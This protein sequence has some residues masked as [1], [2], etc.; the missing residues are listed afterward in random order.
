VLAHNHCYTFNKRP[1]GSSYYL[2]AANFT[3]HWLFVDSVRERLLTKKQTSLLLFRRTNPL[4]MDTVQPKPHE[5]RRVRMVA[6][7][8]F[9]HGA[10]KVF[11]D[12]IRIARSL[13]TGR[14][15]HVYENNVLLA[16][17]KA[18]DG[19]YALQV[20]G[21]RRLMRVFKPPRLRVVVMS[22]VE[23]F[24]RKGGNVFAKHVANVDPEIRAEEEVLVVDGR[25]ELLA[26][27]RSFF[28]AEEMKSFR[29]G[30][31][32]KVRHGVGP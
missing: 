18:R 26:V 20:E 28:N 31:A 17:L 27:G 14:I 9:G 29:V 15:R 25:D 5:L 1:R 19:L 8:Q 22:G 13:S 21:G 7:Y 16:T 10:G 12:T 3:E 30:V 24:I 2:A 32:V 11:P 23:P 6:A 4:S